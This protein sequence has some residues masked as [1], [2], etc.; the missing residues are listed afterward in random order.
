MKMKTRRNVGDYQE[1]GAISCAKGEKTGL[2]KLNN[3]K[4]KT[5]LN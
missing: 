3:K 2:K 5:K 4:K 1:G